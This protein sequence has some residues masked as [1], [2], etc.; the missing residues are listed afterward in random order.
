MLNA[1]LPILTAL[2]KKCEQKLDLNILLRGQVQ[3]SA[4]IY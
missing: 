3:N 4:G 2:Q 1:F